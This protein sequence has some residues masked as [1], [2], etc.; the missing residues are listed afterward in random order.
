VV[1]ATGTGKTVIAAF[2]YRDFCRTNPNRSNRLLFVA[3]RKELLS[4]SLA[5]FRGILKD[6]NFG[7]MMLGGLKP[8]SF[9]HLLGGTDLWADVFCRTV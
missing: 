3:R 6:L 7:S 8:D 1:A 9:D 5:C 2:D 4:Q